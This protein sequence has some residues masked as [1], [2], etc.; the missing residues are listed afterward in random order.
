MDKNPQLKKS[1][2]TS[3]TKMDTTLVVAIIGLIGTLLTALLASP[4]L[5][6]LI[7]KNNSPVNVSTE[8]LTPL[9]PITATNTAVYTA[10]LLPTLTSTSTSTPVGLDWKSIMS[11]RLDSSSSCPPRL[12][13]PTINPADDITI[14]AQQFTQD[15]NNHND[16]SWLL[17]PTGSWSGNI[18][19]HISSIVANTG[20]IKIGNKLTI[21]VTTQKDLPERVN[22]IDYGLCGGAGEVRN[23]PAINFSNNFDTY[24]VKPIYTKAD[25]FTLQPGEF[26]EFSIPFEC[27]SV[28]IYYFKVNVSYEYSNFSGVTDSDETVGFICPQTFTSWRFDVFGH[29]FLSS[30]TYQWN[31]NGYE[32]KP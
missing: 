25:F 30:E 4:V 22:V 16:V 28:G 31:G 2:K 14:A 19:L 10:S 20:W 1:G 26:E 29:Q 9:L 13:P 12:L 27:K 17:A 8:T 11:M 18:G 24:E 3:R 5:I 6:T 32:K 15:F 23:F 21:D 7:Q